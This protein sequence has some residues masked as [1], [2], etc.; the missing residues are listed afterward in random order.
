MNS[1]LTEEQRQQIINDYR[2]GASIASLA[3][4][5]PISESG[6][7]EMLKRRGVKLKGTNRIYSVDETY[8]DVIDTEKK[9]YWLGFISADGHV[10][11]Y[12]VQIQ[13]ARKDKEHLESFKE[14]IQAG[15]PIKD[16]LGQCNT[17]VSCIDIG[18]KKLSK[19]LRRLG[20][21]SN[22]TFNLEPC[23]AVPEHLL[24]HYWR[25]A[26]DG[27]GW[28]SKR[29]K[30]RGYQIGLCS[31]SPAFLEGFRKFVLDHIPNM[32]GKVL[33]DKGKSL[34]RFV[35]SGVTMPRQIAYILYYGTKR[36]L[37]RKRK[38]IKKVMSLE[39][40]LCRNEIC[41]DRDTLSLLYEREG[42]WAAVGYMFDMHRSNFY[43]FRDRLPPSI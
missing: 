26:V 43:K 27:D 13:L 41:M 33:E 7:R 42:N 23:K 29:S 39:D 31:A 30:V 36:S 25:G 21:D 6:I 38:D 16:R 28:I 24:R 17:P 22:K 1:K 5:F 15:H 40:G 11:D 2:D 32:K 3:R 20:L 12:K 4:S 18:S 14:D 8:F 34:Y 10:D 9:A 37:P 35:I 19:A